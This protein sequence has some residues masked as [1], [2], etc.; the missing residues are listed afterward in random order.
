MEKYS[1]N[2]YEKRSL[3]E[4]TSFEDKVEALKFFSKKCESVMKENC[5]IKDDNAVR[6]LKF[7]EAAFFNKR[8]NYN[9]ITGTDI[10]DIVIR[11]E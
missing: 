6:F 3:L 10:D 5:I 2:V 1:V 4:S 9:S 11:I 7:T 8:M